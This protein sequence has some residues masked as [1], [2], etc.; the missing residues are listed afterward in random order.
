MVGFGFE[1]SVAYFDCNLFLKVNHLITINLPALIFISIIDYHGPISQVIYAILN[2]KILICN[3]YTIIC[4]LSNKLSICLKL[5][6]LDFK[7][8][9]PKIKNHSIFFTDFSI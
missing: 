2:R 1:G 7:L 6:N 9:P 4:Y 3:Y 8:H 5:V